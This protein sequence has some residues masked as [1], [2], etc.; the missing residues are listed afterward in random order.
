MSTPM[1]IKPGEAVAFV[2]Y[3]PASSA[4]AALLL[5][6]LL[7]FLLCQPLLQLLLFLATTVAVA[8]LR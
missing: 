1:D 2:F 6:Y 5:F 7:P 4:G 3:L 8:S